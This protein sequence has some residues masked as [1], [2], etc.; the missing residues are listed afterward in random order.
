MNLRHAAGIVINFLRQRIIGFFLYIFSKFV[1]KYIDGAGDFF[2]FMCTEEL[3][4]SFRKLSE[5]EVQELFH[6]TW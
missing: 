5:S 6:I 3:R 1:D 2:L 4:F